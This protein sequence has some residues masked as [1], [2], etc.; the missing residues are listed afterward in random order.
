MGGSSGHLFPLRL[1]PGTTHVPPTEVLA[2]GGHPLS[3]SEGPNPRGRGPKSAG[4]GAQCRGRAYLAEVGHGECLPLPPPPVPRQLLPALA[5]QMSSRPRVAV[6]ST[7]PG[8]GCV[9]QVP[10]RAGVH[11]H[12]LQVRVGAGRR[13]G[14]RS[15]GPGTPTF[16]LS[17]PPRLRAVEPPPV[18]RTLAQ[19]AQLRRGRNRAASSFER[20]PFVPPSTPVLRVSTRGQQGAELG[21]CPSGWPEPRLPP[22]G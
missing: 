22:R 10:E 12:H 7:W 8:P 17:A 21:L 15:R 4:G 18:L 6:L 11:A 2:T 19:T 3:I 16:V 14:T 5:R 20:V 1:Q 13:R 9:G